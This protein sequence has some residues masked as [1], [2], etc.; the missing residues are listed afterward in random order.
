MVEISIIIPSYNNEKYLSECIESVLNQ[1]FTDFELIIVEGG[2][3]DNSM[4]IIQKYA[5]K[6]PRIR[7]LV[8]T[9]NKGVSKARNDGIKASMG[10]YVAIL[11]SDD[12]MLST[13]IEELY[14]EF[15]KDPE[16]GLVHSDVYVIDENGTIK[17]KIIGNKKYSE[18]FIHG[19]VLR[20]R[21]CHIGYPMFRKKCLFTVG[22]YDETLRGGEDY[23]LYNRITRLYP[24]GYVKKPLIFYRRHGTNASSKLELMVD[25][26]KKYLDKTFN[27]DC[28]S[29]DDTILY[30]AY[31][32]YYVDKMNLEVHKKTIPFLIQFPKKIAFMFASNPIYIIRL[33]FPILTTLFLRSITTIQKKLAL[34]FHKEYIQIGW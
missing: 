11:D 9:S 34:F 14:F 28:E 23:D 31:A 4:Q 24:V 2:S 15:L 7:V 3:K 13:R 20:R 19:E 1:T 33:V 18:G 25:H 17:G 22:L 10:E 12:V 8:H 26:Y 16:P 21:G 30:Q 5:D 6:D 32:H 29:C 27:N